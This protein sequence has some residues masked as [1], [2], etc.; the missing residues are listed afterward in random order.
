MD[1]R[2]RVTVREFGSGIYL[3]KAEYGFKETP[4]VYRVLELGQPQIGS[5]CE[6]MDT[7]FFIARESVVPSKLPGMSMWRERLFAWMHQNGAKP[8]DFFHIPAN[9]VVELGTKVEI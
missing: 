8:S 3:V 7:S 5:R 6:L 1:D 2:R 4:D 9:R